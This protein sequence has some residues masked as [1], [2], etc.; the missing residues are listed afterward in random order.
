MSGY[1]MAERMRGE[2]CCSALSITAVPISVGSSCMDP[3]LFA[4]VNTLDCSLKGLSH[5]TGYEKAKLITHEWFIHTRSETNIGLN[6]KHIPV[7]TTDA[8]TH[9]SAGLL[10]ARD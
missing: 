1:V 2:I 3:Q 10:E 9:P 8:I 4:I 7:G 5:Q 6:E